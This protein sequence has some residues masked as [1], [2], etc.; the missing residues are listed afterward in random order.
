MLRA[1]AFVKKCWLVVR[2]VAC[3]GWIMLTSA[4][5]DGIYICDTINAAGTTCSHFAAVLDGVATFENVGLTGAAIGEALGWGLGIVFVLFGMGLG[6]GSAHRVLAV[7][8]GS[9]EREI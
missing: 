5:A 6:L 4:R 9:S 8:L 7:V 1:L 3:L 2:V